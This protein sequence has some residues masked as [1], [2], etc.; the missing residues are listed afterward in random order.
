MAVIFL[1]LAIIFAPVLVFAFA[2]GVEYLY[3][4]E[5][6]ITIIFVTTLLYI[7]FG[8]F[9]K[10]YT[11]RHEWLDHLSLQKNTYNGTTYFSQINKDKD[12]TISSLE[13]SIED[14][15]GYD[16]SFKFEGKFER[17]FKL[18]GLST[19][20]QSGNKKFDE[21]IYIISDDPKVCQKLKA[22]DK[23]RES[24]YKLFWSYYDQGIKVKKVECFDGRLLVDAKNKNNTLT[25]QEATKYFQAS[26]ELMQDILDK[27]PSIEQADDNIYREESGKIAF[28]LRVVTGALLFNG[29]L[30]LF[31]DLAHL[32]PLPQ[33]VEPFS[34]IGLS[35]IITI[36]VLL[37]FM[38]ITYWYLRKSS[39][40]S[41]VLLEMFTFGALAIFCTSLVEVKEINM[42]FDNSQP[43]NYKVKVINKEMHRGHRGRTRYYVKI[44]GWRG[45][46]QQKI[47]INST[48]YR[49]VFA[50]MMIEVQ[51]HK[52]LL[53]YSWIDL[54]I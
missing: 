16:F 23:L 22:N 39:R 54:A 18:L 27:F 35:L 26:I 51:E 49:Q 6:R 40:F 28:I 4:P 41:P 12:E 20:C 46:S 25:D 52:G 37:F 53:G 7:W 1:T 50:N 44:S 34:I 3:M 5:Y 36:F 31:F 32:K 29:G 13:L 19:E 38:L 45:L 43:T 30:V 17:F 9:R 48:L 8:L 21:S 33:L 47:A 2:Y 42:L 24:L 15:Y 10:K 14:I 11:K